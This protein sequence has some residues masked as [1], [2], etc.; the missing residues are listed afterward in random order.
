MV[1]LFLA[2]AAFVGTHFLLSH[3]LRAPMVARLG[4]NGFR[5]VYSLLALVTLAWVAYAFHMAPKDAPRWTVD[6]NLWIIATII[7]WIASVL[8]AGSFS[9]NPALPDP[10]AVRNLE[11][12]VSGVF[13]IT[14]HPMM[15][16]FALWGIAHILVMPTGANLLLSVSIIVLAL[17]G[18]AGQD[19][20]KARL[21]GESWQSWTRRTSYVPF[22]LPITGRAQWRA[23]IP[24]L[25][26]LASG[27]L[28]W[29]GATFA[30]GAIGAGIW[31]WI[32]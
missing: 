32:Y 7:M 24:S 22:V 23:I 12:P 3:P 1:A 11:R 5:G 8:F 14:R 27:T 26:V 13:A 10:N 19:A 29:L 17:G 30:H 28:V 4:E 18:A 15:W 20:K 6:D 21:M 16:S 25:V 9:R 31:R 2:C